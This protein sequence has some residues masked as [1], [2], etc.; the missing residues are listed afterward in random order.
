M[1]S[2]TEPSSPRDVI[3]VGAG[4]AGLT[5]ALYLARYRRAPLV[6]HD[7]KGRALRI[8]LAR[9]APGFPEG[10]RGRKLIAL[11]ARH[12][13]QYGAEIEE[14]EVASIE[15]ERGGFRLHLG[16]GSTRAGRAVLLATGVD[17]NQIELPEAVHEAAIQ[18]GVLRYCPICDGYEHISKRIGVIGCDTNGAAEAL[19]LRRYSSHVTLMP[20]NRSELSPAEVL[21]LAEAG[22]GWK[23]AA[24]SDWNRRPIT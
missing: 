13:V 11:M 16:D 9:N 15:A 14:A 3:I 23:E 17:L 24:F 18:A 19:F 5:A 22:S 4:P 7:G 21:D 2:T 10:V 1:N 12:A 20:L 8:P 6:M